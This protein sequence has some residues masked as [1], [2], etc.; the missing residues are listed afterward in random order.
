MLG[1]RTTVA[2]AGGLQR[3]VILIAP[4]VIV[5]VVTLTLVSRVVGPGAEPANGAGPSSAITVL[6]D[7]T[8]L[9]D[10]VSLSYGRG[11]PSTPKP[12]LATLRSGKAGSA[13]GPTFP[14]PAGLLGGLLGFTPPALVPPA[15]A[16]LSIP[17]A[18][19]AGPPQTYRT[20]CVRLCDGSF[21]PVSFS[22]SRDRFGDDEAKCQAGCDAPSRLFVYATEGGS[23]ETMADVQGHPYVAL[24][25]AFKFRATYD[26]ACKCRAH[27]WE[28]EAMV[29]HARYANAEAKGPSSSSQ[30][31]QAPVAGAA[32]LV[33]DV[34]TT[35]ALAIAAAPSSADSAS[36]EVE[37]SSTRVLALDMVTREPMPMPVQ[38][39][40]KRAAGATTARPI[41]PAKLAGGAQ[42]KLVR[43]ASADDVFRAGFGR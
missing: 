35:A 36:I 18:V 8:S 32:P 16:S 20:V 37:T 6:G 17:P 28:Q 22:T 29:R 13:P 19:V 31:S 9:A 38:R 27:P 1:S 42:Q 30:V 15:P 26:P 23:P 5:Q 11:T 34:G 4:A 40:R 43:S 24:A 2:P 10:V 14:R 33:A 25:T 21:F 41:V 7:S 3:W 12:S 39:A